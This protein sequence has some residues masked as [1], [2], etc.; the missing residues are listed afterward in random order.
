M[1]LLADEGIDAIAD[2]DQ[3]L[4]NA[5]TVITPQRIRIRPS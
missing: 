4:V 5:F 3:E 2:H 1:N